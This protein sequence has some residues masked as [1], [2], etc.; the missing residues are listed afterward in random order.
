MVPIL[1]YLFIYLFAAIQTRE[2]SGTKINLT[3]FFLKHVSFFPWVP[4]FSE[5]RE[6]IKPWH[7]SLFS[8]S[9]RHS[10]CSIKYRW[11]LLFAVGGEAFSRQIKLNHN[12]WR[13]MPL[14]NGKQIAAS[15]GKQPTSA[16]QEYKTKT[17]WLIWVWACVGS[18]RPTVFICM[19]WPE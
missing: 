3:F 1:E 10:N 7:V 12:E 14:H 9:L 13:E 15:E 17:I 19:V 11:Q 18:Q 6:K 16:R 4:I 2:T 5:E 8:L